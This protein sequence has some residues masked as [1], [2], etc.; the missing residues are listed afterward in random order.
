MAGRKQEARRENKPASRV[1]EGV[2]PVKCLCAAVRGG[3]F[4]WSS[5]PF[6]ARVHAQVQQQKPPG[7]RG[8]ALGGLCAAHWA[9]GSLDNGSGR[10]REQRLSAAKNKKLVTPNMWENASLALQFATSPAC[11]CSTKRSAQGANSAAEWMW[12]SSSDAFS[13][14][15]SPY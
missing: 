13:R 12:R 5:H 14:L 7:A 10:T 9:A 6:E 8:R 11:P 4:A 2:G 3:G 1:A 15:P